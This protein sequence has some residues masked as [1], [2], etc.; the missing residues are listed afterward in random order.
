MDNNNEK[1]T[2]KIAEKPKAVPKKNPD[3]RSGINIES[4]IKISDP[5]SGKILVE[6]RA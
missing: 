4:K 2:L 3:E 6:G 1:E 5:E